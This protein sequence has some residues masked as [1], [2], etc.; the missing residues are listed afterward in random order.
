MS[1]AIP[2]RG[3][4][5]RWS[6]LS[7]DVRSTVETR[8]AASIVGARDQTGGFSPGLAAI[9]ELHD[10][11]RVFVKGASPQQN[12]DT[13]RIYRREA[14]LAPHLPRHP[15]LPRFL[16][17]IDQ[18]HDGWVLLAFEAIEGREPD[19]PWQDHDIERVL[20][21]MEDLSSACT[22]ATVPARSASSV[23]PGVVGGW[24][25]IEPSAPASL[26]DWSRQYLEQLISL[27][28]QSSRAVSGETLL[29]LD[30]RADNILLTEDSVVFVDWPDAAVGEAWVDLLVWAP[31][32]RVQGGPDPE[33]LL[34]RYPPA[35]KA[36]PKD[37]TAVVCAIAGYFTQR[38]LLP[39]PPGLPTLRA[40]QAVQAE[41]TRAWLAQRT[42]WD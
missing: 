20:A 34:R 39:P 26:D 41:V 36:A 28:R 3:R 37:V 4:R 16:W 38:S 15:S 22:P 9:L 25:L 10:G 40:F 33:T 24:G 18:G 12:P 8:L 13:P 19:L 27:E 29:H 35:R 17:A 1:A 5:C 31:S 23:F 30:I 6:D 11:S 14:Q 32:L 2:T 42:G 7:A 21:A